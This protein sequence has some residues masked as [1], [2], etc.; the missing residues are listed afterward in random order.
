MAP[1]AQGAYTDKF[2]LSYIQIVRNVKGSGPDPR[3]SQN[4]GPGRERMLR[5]TGRAA[6]GNTART[7]P[8][9]GQQGPDPSAC[10]ATS[11]LD[12]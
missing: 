7:G 11:S 4:K 10:R 3:N 12:T 5:T 2:V 8:G 6:S 9:E 1:S